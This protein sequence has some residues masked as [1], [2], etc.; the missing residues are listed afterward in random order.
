MLKQ[1]VLSLSLVST[2]AFGCGLHQSTGFNFVTEPGSLEVFDS[3][4]KVRQLDMLGNSKKPDHF[5]LFA[6][7]SALAS[8]NSNKIEF[9]IFEAIKGHYSQ[10]HYAEGVLVEGRKTLPTSDDLLLVTEL[11]VLDALAT[12]RINWQ[13]AKRA[14][15]IVINGQE[16]EVAQLDKW[17]SEIFI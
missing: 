9:S 17:F 15:L 14:G 1:V 12:K 6:I 10:V 11:D 7:K 3:V 2:L 13:T 4:I 8:E 16:D 5:R